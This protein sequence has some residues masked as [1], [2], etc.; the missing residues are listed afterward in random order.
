M[1]AFK[2]YGTATLI[3]LSALILLAGGGAK[4]AGVPEVHM[5]FGILGLPSW[6]GYFIGVCELQEQSASLFDHYVRLPQ[7]GLVRL[8]WVRCTFM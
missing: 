8:C 4:L 7:P 1:S 3:A 6:F 2:K 5:S